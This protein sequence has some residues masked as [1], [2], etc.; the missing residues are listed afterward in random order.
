LAGVYSLLPSAAD[1]IT[2]LIWFTQSTTS[3]GK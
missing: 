2:G 1:L 3:L